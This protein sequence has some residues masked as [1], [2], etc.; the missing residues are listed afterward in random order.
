MQPPSN[1]SGAIPTELRKILDT[2][3]E[4]SS[5][6]SVMHTEYAFGNSEAGTYYPA[7]IPAIPIL[8]MIVENEEG[9]PRWTAIEILH[10]WLFSFYPEQK[11]GWVI[12]TNLP[13]DDLQRLVQAEILNLHSTFER[14]GKRDDL[15]KGQR[16]YI[17]DFLSGL[18]DDR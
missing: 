4:A 16:R 5:W 3:D 9:W 7:I 12:D 2:H 8:A 6:Q 15:S 18:D 10:D 13:A 11:H 14:I 1:S 17:E